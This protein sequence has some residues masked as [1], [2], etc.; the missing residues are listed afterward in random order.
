MAVDWVKLEKVV[1][2]LFLQGLCRSCYF[3]SRNWTCRAHGS[4][5]VTLQLEEPVSTRLVSS[6][7]PFVSFPIPFFGPG[8]LKNKTAIYFCW[9][10]SR[11][12][13]ALSL[14]FAVEEFLVD[15]YYSLSLSSDFDLTPLLSPE[16]D[17]NQWKGW[18][19]SRLQLDFPMT[20]WSDPIPSL[21]HSPFL[22]SLTWLS[23][24]QPTWAQSF[25]YTYG[26]KYADGCYNRS[27]GILSPSIQES[28]LSDLLGLVSFLVLSPTINFFKPEDKICLPPLL[29]FISRNKSIPYFFSSS[30]F[31]GSDEMLLQVTSTTLRRSCR[32]DG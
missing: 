29:I 31:Y 22:P 21:S 27:Y 28:V 13:I 7:G 19:R 10:I 5:E 16:I 8:C 12:I 9:L 11:R 15:F 6:T 3:L 2:S 26:L 17:C 32:V 1:S 25:H 30:C 14:F 18:A 24:Y 20:R 23:C 4:K